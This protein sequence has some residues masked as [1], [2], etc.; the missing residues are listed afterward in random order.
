MRRYDLGNIHIL[1]IVLVGRIRISF[2]RHS[3]SWKKTLFFFFVGRV[4]LSVVGFALGDNQKGFCFCFVS[5]SS[6]TGSRRRDK[7]PQGVVKVVVVQIP[8][9]G[10]ESERQ[11]FRRPPFPKILVYCA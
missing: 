7:H 9:N 6:Q 1:D 8:R 10:G 3:P 11:R 2:R 4:S 5:K